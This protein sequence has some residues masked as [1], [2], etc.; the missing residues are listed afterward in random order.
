MEWKEKCVTVK[1]EKLL[2]ASAKNPGRIRE[3][4]PPAGDRPL[5]FNPFE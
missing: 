3:S 1:I 2:L 4:Q 5:I